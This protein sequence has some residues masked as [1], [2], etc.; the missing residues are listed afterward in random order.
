MKRAYVD[1]TRFFPGLPAS[2]G[3]RWGVQ[4]GSGGSHRGGWRPCPGLAGRNRERRRAT[5]HRFGARQTG[6]RR[7]RSHAPRGAEEVSRGALAEL[8]AQ[9]WNS[10]PTP[11]RADPL[12]RWCHQM[13]TDWSDNAWQLAARK[14]AAGSIRHPSSEL[15]VPRGSSTTRGVAG[16]YR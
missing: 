13:W 7:T 3:S 16:R 8:P 12:A 4:S 11:P 5:P 2:A 14:A 9:A 10:A 15:A 6:D 1:R